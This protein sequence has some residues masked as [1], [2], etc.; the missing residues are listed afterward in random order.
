MMHCNAGFDAL[1]KKCNLTA[2]HSDVVAQVAIY[3]MRQQGTF[4]DFS[5]KLNLAI[6]E[7]IERMGGDEDTQIQSYLFCLR[8]MM[9]S[10]TDT[11]RLIK[12]QAT[13]LASG[14]HANVNSGA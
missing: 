7:L 11:I 5:N 6:F 8:T 2:R 12:A 13:I 1:F 14:N 9:T 3:S 4:P 10:W